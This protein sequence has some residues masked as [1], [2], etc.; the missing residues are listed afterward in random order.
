M[1]SNK[2]FDKFNWI[3]ISVLVFLILWIIVIGLFEERLKSQIDI[4]WSNIYS[5]KVTEQKEKCKQIFDEYQSSL[6]K[7]TNLIL[8]SD[9]IKK[10]IAN[11]DIN[12]IF[13]SYEKLNLSED[14]CC[15]IYDRK[16][17]LLFFSG[18]ELL[19]DMYLL[20]KCFTGRSFSFI[21]N[22]GFYSYL[23]I[24]SP[25]QDAESDVVAVSVT[26]SLL[27]VTFKN[28]EKFFPD[29]G[30]TN[31][32]INKIGLSSPKLINS[33]SI[34]LSTLQN[35]GA[36]NEFLLINGIDG[37][38]IGAI[39]L[40]QYDKRTYT[41]ELQ[42]TVA[43]F[44][45][46]LVLFITIIIGFLFYRGM[47]LIKNDKVDFLKALMSLLLLVFIRYL[48]LIFKFP[49][50]IL[51]SDLFNPQHFATGTF[52]GLAKSLGEL[53]ITFSLLLI[54]IVYVAKIFST[55][56]NI[57]GQKNNK[58]LLIELAI[59]IILI[60]SFILILLLYFSTFKNIITDSNIKFLDKSSIIPSPE[61]LIIN[62]VLLI[63][64][65]ILIF[66]NCSLLIISY[67]RI[68]KLLNSSL[69]KRFLFVI[70]FVIFSAISI[71]LSSYLTLKIEKFLDLFIV[72]VIFVAGYYI[73]KNAYVQ[74]NLKLFNLKN[75]YIVILA[76]VI[77]MP[78]VLLYNLK[79]KE[80]DYIESLGK[81]ITNL[82]E[83]KAIIIL[84]N[85]LHDINTD[86]SIENSIL[87]K[88]KLQGL[89]F[90]LW[91]E[92]KLIS[93]SYNSAIIILDSNKKIVSD[94]NISPLSIETDSVLKYASIKF[95]NKP[96]IFSPPD[97][98]T[99]VESLEEIDIENT[100]YD[101]Y[102]VMFENV[103]IFKNPIEKY[104]IGI[105]SIEKS[106]YKNTQRAKLLGYVL[107]VLQSDVKNFVTQQQQLF[108]SQDKDN[109]LYKL[110]AKPE[111]SE[112]VNSEIETA[113][114]I[115]VA[116]E[117]KN[118]IPEFSNYVFTSK[119][120]NLWKKV[121]INDEEYNTYFYFAEPKNIDEP[122]LNTP[123]RI[124]ALTTKEK[125][126]GVYIFYFFK[127]IL[128]NILIFI[129]VYILSSLVTSYRLKNI[130]FS[131]RNKLFLIFLLIS[132]I[133]IIAL[134]FY[135][136]A[137]II[138]KYDT[139][140]Q[141]Q[142]LSD[143]SLVSEVLSSEKGYPPNV[144]L[145]PDTTGRRYKNALE[146]YFIK[147][148][149]N[150]NIFINN[151]L[152]STTSDELFKSDLLSKRLDADAY[153]NLVLLRKDN[154]FKNRHI[155]AI[156]FFEG[157]KPIFDIGNKISAIVSSVTL[158]R[159]NEINE[160]LTETI[161][162]IFGSYIIVVILIL[163]L[164]KFFTDRLS[165]P[166]L[167]LKEA[168]EKVARA[169]PNIKIDI[170]RSDEL[171]ILVDAFNKM[172]KDLEVSK[173]QQKRAEREAA[174]RDIAMRV[175]HEIKNPLTPI[176]L[177]IQ[178]L[179]KVFKEMKTREEMQKAVEDTK[180]IIIREIDRLNKIATDF[181]NFAKM[182]TRHYEL[183]NVNEVLEEVLTLYSFEERITII[184]NLKPDLPLIRADRQELNRIFQNIVKNAFQAILEKGTITANSYFDDKFVYVEIIDTG[185]GME[186]E[187]LEKL[188]EPNFST[189]SSGMGLGLAITKK[190][191]DDIK[192]SITIESKVNV[193]TKV[194]LKF[195]I[196]ID[197][198][199]KA[200]K[201]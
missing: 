77:L 64:T 65:F 10:A 129:I 163:I 128:I 146:R 143:L 140:T 79:L 42:E 106:Q 199:D 183:I 119:K 9:E 148:D 138:N 69:I 109:L 122:N 18:R 124:I 68:K 188:F 85:V 137:F 94:F 82:E 66:L 141:S 34:E 117:V 28:K 196:Y 6:L 91:S 171:G 49:S 57:Y 191:L 126:Y 58:S 167:I 73:V 21:K 38:V 112:F 23:L 120:K 92:S 45:S 35:K 19:P 47:K 70:L 83:E 55:N 192:A 157:Y 96:Y 53:F 1:N 3:L 100:D 36:D 165:K 105:T 121:Y 22:I 41:A 48:W 153:Y 67:F 33:E 39:I 186:E 144:K 25:I 87:D 130:K 180:V 108:R 150:F 115:V 56:E 51:Q 74:R 14:F 99:I 147:T 178:H 198:N 2:F 16:F 142:I 133:P 11:K 32:I 136:R 78:I 5:E 158:F 8:S 164:V 63:V 187:V 97:N 135:T 52:V 95:F 168:T 200:I 111:V 103:T 172:I 132:V 131:F 46:I 89:A 173:E 156:T 123:V 176:K 127:Y 54:W 13:A 88:S 43:K 15:E 107:I 17:N 98:D 159:Q 162:F 125:D 86:K 170:K 160:E 181:S 81:S 50:E 30:L 134:G 190:S 12:K 93:E 72:F 118:F 154:F 189:K 60:F 29:I 114:D 20:Q 175:A 59:Q 27:D 62:L 90:K 194:I 174:W 104:Y 145:L 71:A 155:G 151:K 44:V 101:F 31:Q 149:K 26:A 197:N 110:I 152:V 84:S 193:G 139:S 184:K 195:H 201:K 4:K 7:Y 169:E 116:E 185:I 113:T 37:S 177:S 166:I 61:L 75:F 102:P 80:P 179:S 40:D 76:S 161:T 24:F 182:P